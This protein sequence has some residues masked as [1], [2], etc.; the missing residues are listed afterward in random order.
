MEMLILG[1]FFLNH[2]TLI[3]VFTFFLHGNRQQREASSQMPIHSPG[4]DP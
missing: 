3:S 4:T 1:D 2:L